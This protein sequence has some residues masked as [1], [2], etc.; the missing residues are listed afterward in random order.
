MPKVVPPPA[1]PLCRLQDIADGGAVAVEAR[2]EDGDES[3]IV[4]RRGDGA[5]AY[6]NV[7]PHAGRRLDWAPGRFLFDDGVLVCAVHGA[8]FA[9][10]SGLCIGGPCRGEHLSAVPVAVVDGTVVLVASGTAG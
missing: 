5:R 2:L 9:V 1:P 4:L 7:C 8:S 10:D 3:L 6:R